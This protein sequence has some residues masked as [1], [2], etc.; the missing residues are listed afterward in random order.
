MYNYVIVINLMAQYSFCYGQSFYSPWK[1]NCQSF[2]CE[3]VIT[4]PVWSWGHM[5]YT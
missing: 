5:R 2:C 1:V 3:N 4:T